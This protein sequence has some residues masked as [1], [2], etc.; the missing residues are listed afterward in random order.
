[1]TVPLLVVDAANVVGSVPDGWWRD[2]P[3]A[4]RRL[5]DALVAYAESGLP[6][7][8]IDPPL[9]GP[10]EVVLVV[11][12]AARGV[13]PVPGVRV[14]AADGSGDDRVVEVVAGREAGRRCVVVTADRRLRERVGALGAEVTGPRTV[15]P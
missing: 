6:P 13:E 14:T 1:M 11:E 5:R 3:G 9:P 2:R 12:G 8:A 15:R 4:A 10:L 7:A